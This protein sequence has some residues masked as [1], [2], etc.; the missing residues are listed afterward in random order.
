VNYNIMGYVQGDYSL[1]ATQHSIGPGWKT[2]VT[3]LW[4]V[5]KSQ[6]PPVLVQQVKEKWGGLRFYVGGAP[7]WIHDLIDRIEELSYKICESCGKPGRPRT[8]GWVKTRCDECQA[9]F[10][11]ERDM[12]RIS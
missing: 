1:D 5:C 2:L 9:E 10:E 7:R 8:D 4:L 11:H 12:K 3:L 6:N